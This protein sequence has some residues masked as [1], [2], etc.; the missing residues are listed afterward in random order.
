[1]DNAETAIWVFGI[2]IVAILAFMGMGVLVY[3]TVKQVDN[4]QPC[5]CG[6]EV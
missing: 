1:M 6:Q 2:M 3:K 5:V 4:T